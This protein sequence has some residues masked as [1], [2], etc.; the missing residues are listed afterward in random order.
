MKILFIAPLPPPINGHSLAAQV[1]LEGLIRT[2]DVQVVNLSVG[3]TG[4]GALSVKRVIEVAKVLIDVVRRR[5]GAD[6]IYFTISESLAG[7]IKDVLIYCLCAGRLA[8]IYI[9]LHGGSIKTQLF[10]RYGWL[11]AVNALFIRRV[12]G[13]IISGKSHEPIFADMV[14]KQRVHVVANFAKD[15]L[16]V[17]EQTIIGKF[18]HRRPLRILYI[19]NM[20]PMKGYDEL[21]DAYLGLDEPVRAQMRLDFAGRFESASLQARFVNKIAD[22]EG[23]RY[24]G[25][26]DDVEKQSLFSRAHVFC[27]PTAFLEG[28]PISILEAYASGCV[29]LTTGQSGIR[30]VFAHGVNGFELRQRSAAGIA[31]ALV[32]LVKDSSGLQEMALTNRATAGSRYRTS[33]Y[34]SALQTI[35]ESVATA[36]GR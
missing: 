4:D 27:L 28:Q 19:S 22:I 32:A 9:H 15:S 3:S 8:T 35:V 20:I 21:A 5:W 11:R 30:D 36:T 1:F 23:I 25:V 33:S 16:F 24:H 31:R 12:A 14:P 2:H 18:N 34:N 13:V 6:A 7:N 26:V 17:T 10:D 29:V